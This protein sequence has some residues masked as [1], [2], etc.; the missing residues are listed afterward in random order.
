[1]MGLGFSILG[2]GVFERMTKISE[3]VRVLFIKPTK[4]TKADL[5]QP[6]KK[7]KLRES[8]FRFLFGPNNAQLKL[9]I[10]NIHQQ[11]YGEN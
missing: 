8:D 3:G 1:M 9:R 7:I 4:A 6:T 5:L 11:C 2:L 10:H